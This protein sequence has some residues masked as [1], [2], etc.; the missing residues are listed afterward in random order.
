MHFS[1][2]KA[3]NGHSMS[4]GLVEERLCANCLS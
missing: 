2:S 3:A 4:F 1:S